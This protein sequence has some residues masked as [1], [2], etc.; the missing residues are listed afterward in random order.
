MKELKVLGRKRKSCTSQINKDIL[1]TIFTS[2][3]T[4]SSTILVTF[5]TV[6]TWAS[7]FRRNSYFYILFVFFHAWIHSL[8]NGFFTGVNAPPPI[9]PGLRS[10]RLDLDWRTPW[11]CQLEERVCSWLTTP[12]AFLFPEWSARGRPFGE[13]W[14][15]V[16]GPLRS[17]LPLGRIFDD[18]FLCGG[19]GHPDVAKGF[20]SQLSPD[21][22]RL[23]QN[24]T[25][26]LIPIRAVRL[27]IFCTPTLNERRR[28]WNSSVLSIDYI[29]N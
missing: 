14:R 4:F 2:T 18:R 12:P 21:A 5:S 17:H 15:T 27:P 13:R 29:S 7:V 10:I 23:K 26:K 6:V 16:R 19:S 25:R 20:V 9:Q 11:G 1:E 8:A 24:C 28:T 3:S 22:I